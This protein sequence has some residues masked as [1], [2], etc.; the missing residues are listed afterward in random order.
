V[1]GML[2][3]AGLLTRVS[4]GLLSCTMV[5]ALLTADRANFLGALKGTSDAGLTDIVPFVYLLFLLWLVIFGPGLVSL[6]HLLF[7]RIAKND[8]AS[9]RAISERLG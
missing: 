1:G 9:S 2:L 6:D 4:A 7:L 8:P 5:V 3:I